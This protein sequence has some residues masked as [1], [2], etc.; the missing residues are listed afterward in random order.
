MQHLLINKLQL[1]MNQPNFD[2]ALT[3]IRANHTSMVGLDILNMD[4]KWTNYQCTLMVVAIYLRAA[5][6]NSHPRII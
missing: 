4:Y 5:N 6:F 2:V 1:H 3:S